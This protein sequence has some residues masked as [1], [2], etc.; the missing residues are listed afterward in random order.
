[1]YARKLTK[2]ELMEN[3]ITE[4]TTD[5]HVFKGKDE[6]IPNINNGGYF[7]HDIYDKDENGNRIKIDKKNSAFGYVYKL[8]S[9]GLHRLMWAWHFGEVPEGMVVDHINNC[10]DKLEDYALSNLQLLTPGEN[11]AKER[12]DWNTK[13]IKCNLSKPRSFYEQKLEGYNLAYEQAKKDRDA[14]AAHHLRTNISQ[15]RARLRY[16]DN[17]IEEYQAK[18]IEKKV[19]EHDCH[20]RAEKR[21][22]LQANVDSARKFYKELRDAYG[23]DDPIVYQYWGEWKLAIA[24]L[25][26]FCAE[27]KNTHLQ[28][29]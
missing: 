18:S 8:R 5:G 13:E 24:M 10:H 22:E 26:G 6:E 7:V 15:T 11:I 1:M 29:S 17:H 27:T 12:P 20:A 9:L 14:K 25:H 23:K 28:I 21:R 2:E 19:T 16:Y 3:G 4:V